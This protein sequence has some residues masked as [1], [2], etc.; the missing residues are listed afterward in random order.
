MKLIPPPKFETKRLIIR[1][2]K[3]EDAKSIFKWASK[4]KV[5]NLLTWPPY[6]TVEGVESFILKR[7]KEHYEKNIWD[8]LAITFKGSD[9]VIGFVGAFLAS[10]KAKCLEIGY[11][12]DDVHWGKEIMAEAVYELVN[13]LFEKTDV[14]RIQVHTKDNNLNSKRVIEKL[15]FIKEGTVRDGAY[16]KGEFWTTHIYSLLRGEKLNSL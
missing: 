14:H 7:I 10:E 4:E 16:V 8:P 2:I 3:P 9:D 15:G 1:P 6:E 5:V 12:L 13:Q 11:V